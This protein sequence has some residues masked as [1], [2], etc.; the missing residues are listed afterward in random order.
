MSKQR[1]HTRYPIQV[2]VMHRPGTPGV[3]PGAGW[4]RDVSEGGMCIELA[5]VLQPQM[6]V[7]LRLR[8]DRGAI[9]ADGQ[10]AWVGQA[11]DKGGGT[12]H[13]ITLTQMAPGHQK[14]LADLVYRKGELLP[15]QIRVP[16]KLSVLLRSKGRADTP[17]EGWT[18]NLSRGGM[19]LQLPKAFEP[20]TQVEFTL[21]TAQGPLTLNASV[22]WVDPP[23]RRRPGEPIG[24]GVQFTSI[25]WPTL[26][27]LGQVLAVPEE[28]T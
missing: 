18:G 21:H 11:S 27:V 25:G 22:V 13:G 17:L 26:L 24:H 19:L 8:I 4:T 5:D 12:P 14:A 9:E 3:K 2:P 23:E 1:R 10:V 7:R 15:V 20:A 28:R 16:L 6:P